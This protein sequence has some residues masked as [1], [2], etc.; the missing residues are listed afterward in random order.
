MTAPQKSSVTLYSLSPKFGSDF[1]HG[2][3]LLWLSIG[4]KMWYTTVSIALWEKKDM[5][6]IGFDNQKYLTT[7]SAQIRQRIAQYGGKLYLEFG[8]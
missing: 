3:S 7:Q 1:L 4:E 2:K 5:T 8:G 6:K